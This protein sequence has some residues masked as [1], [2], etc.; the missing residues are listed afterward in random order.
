[1][2]KKP[3]LLFITD[4]WSTLDHEKDSSLRI[5]AEC[6]KLGASVYWCSHHDVSLIKGKAVI[7]AQRYLEVSCSLQSAAQKELG[8]FDQVHYRVDPPVNEKYLHPLLML[9]AASE[10]KTEFVNPIAAIL[11]SSEKLFGIQNQKLVPATVVSANVETLAQAIEK[12]QDA[13]VKP[14]NG[15]QSKGVQVY[16]AGKWS[17]AQIRTQLVHLTLGE[18]LPLVVQKFMPEIEDGETRL[19]FV[20]SKLVAYAKKKPSAQSPIIDMDRGSTLE[21]HRLTAAEKKALPALK[22]IL[23]QNRV[24]LAAVDLIGAKLTDFNVTSPGLVVQIEKCTG[25]KLGSLIAKKL[26]KP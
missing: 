13:V 26:L 19:W 16:R 4:P 20:D 21:T 9:K 23:E 15:A 3:N 7:K 17:S 18:T 24:R 5:M 14:L 8:F 25:I 11:T 6:A 2:K 22:K 1:M 12:L 10:K